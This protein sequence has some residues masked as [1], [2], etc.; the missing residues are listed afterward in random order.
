VVK[1]VADESRKTIGGEQIGYYG[2]IF[3]SYLSKK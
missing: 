1:K 2:E 3:T